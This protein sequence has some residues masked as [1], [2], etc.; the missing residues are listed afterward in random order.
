MRLMLSATAALT[1]LALPAPALAA[2]ALG[3]WHPVGE[4][5]AE[6]NGH[7]A[8][9][10]YD[11][12]VLVVGGQAFNSATPGGVEIFNPAQGTWTTAAPTAVARSRHAAIRLDDGRV[13]V[14]GGNRLAPD[15]PSLP[16]ASAELFDP[17]AGS[18][19][20]AAS[21]A[22]ARL[23]PTATLLG[24]GRVLVAGGGADAESATASAEIYDPATDRWTRAAPM[25][26]PRIEA[27]ALLL[28]TGEVLVAGGASSAA[29]QD[30]S[31]DTAELYDPRT[32]RWRPTPK[33]AAA[34]AGADSAVLG[35]GN[36][37]LAGGLD[38]Q[39]GYGIAVQATDLYNPAH[40]TWS[41]GPPLLVARGQ[42][43][44]ALLGNGSFLVVGGTSRSNARSESTAELLDPL[45]QRW[46][47]LPLLP[48]TRIGATVTA[49]PGDRALVVGGSR[50]QAAELFAPPAR[51]APG[52]SPAL[53]SAI[54]DNRPLLALTVLLLLGVAIQA[55]WKRR[56]GPSSR[57]RRAK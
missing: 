50:R 22:S 51:A 30:G 21:M 31:F 35:D 17:V 10:L 57:I 14:I 7:S 5:A 16:V 18:W 34:H 12:T 6:H 20:P 11:G 37:L 55:G 40:N 39:G 3:S 25:T 2:G 56:L 47:L 24:D 38:Y 36:V 4:T 32:D 15:Q 8:T 27:S 45:A 43:G 23:Q 52:G 19:S 29:N 41:S 53:S 44:G 46:T 49:V 42:A 33:M 9:L 48:E 1:L 28:R 54:A 26:T 13:L